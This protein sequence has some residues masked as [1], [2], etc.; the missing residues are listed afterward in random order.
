MNIPQIQEMGI[1]SYLVDLVGRN[2][3]N[4]YHNI[5]RVDFNGKI[6]DCPLMD[7]TIVPHPK[8]HLILI[9][10]KESELDGVGLDDDALDFLP[11]T[12]DASGGL[13]DLPLIWGFVVPRHQK[14]TGTFPQNS[15]ASFS[16]EANMFDFDQLRVSLSP[17]GSKDYTSIEKDNIDKRYGNIGLFMNDDAILLKTRGGSITMNE[18]GIHFGGKVNWEYSKHSKEVVIDNPLNGW[19]PETIVTFPLSIPYYPNFGKMAQIASTSHNLIQVVS[20]STK[21]INAVT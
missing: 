11:G 4:P 12:Y 8:K 17:E 3:Y 14:V 5:V 16:M 2:Y 13:N 15:S 10:T 7:K 19:I 18:D 21:I 9:L 6:I 20:T 1:E